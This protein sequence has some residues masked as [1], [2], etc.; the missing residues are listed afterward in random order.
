MFLEA[1]GMLTAA[2]AGGGVA[3]PGNL[4]VCLVPNADSAQEAIAS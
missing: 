1:C 4:L 2:G 3:P